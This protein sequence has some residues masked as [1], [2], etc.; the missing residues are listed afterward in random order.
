MTHGPVS[1][2]PVQPEDLPAVLALNSE[3]APAV[4]L[5]NMETLRR[6]TAHA[7]LAWVAIVEG[8]IAGYLIGFSCTAPYDGEEF[9]WF[10]S[11]GEAFLYVDQIAVGKARRGRGTGTAFYSA[12]QA[13]AMRH[14]WPSLTCEVN[15]EPPNPGSLAFH[16]RHGFR[17]IGR[18][19][20]ADGRHVVLLRKELAGNAGQS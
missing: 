11:Q 13:W 15:L 8:A 2:R 5:L 19:R 4:S 7:T 18:L 6:L 1:I 17:E 12:L 9:G 20:T 14:G 3:A 16:L 10:R